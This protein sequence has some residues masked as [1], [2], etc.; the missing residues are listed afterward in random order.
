LESSGN[1]DGFGIIAKYF[2]RGVFDKPQQESIEAGVL[3]TLDPN[4]F[5]DLVGTL[6]TELKK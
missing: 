3:P 1:S 2:G 5:Q 4:L 6:I